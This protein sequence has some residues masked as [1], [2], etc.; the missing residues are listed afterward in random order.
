M[1]AT[2]FAPAV[3][4]GG[5]TPVMVVLLVTVRLVSAVPPIVAAVTLVKSVPVIVTEVPPARG[6]LLG[7]I[8]VTV[9]TDP[10]L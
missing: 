6:P 5:V 2:S 7:V 1:T 8:D 10:E 4:A 9:G 3:L